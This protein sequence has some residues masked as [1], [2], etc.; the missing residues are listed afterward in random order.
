MKKI[1]L[2]VAGVL[3]IEVALVDALGLN[4]VNGGD[5]VDVCHLPKVVG[6]CRG[7]FPRF[8]FNSKTR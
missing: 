5:D 1:I 6:R 7:S 3:L 4:D 2:F 8:Y